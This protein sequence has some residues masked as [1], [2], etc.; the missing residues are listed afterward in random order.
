MP[1]LLAKGPDPACGCFLT[2]YHTRDSP[3]RATSERSAGWPGGPPSVPSS[4][5]RRPPSLKVPRAPRLPP[6]SVPLRAYIEMDAGDTLLTGDKSASPPQAGNTT[7]L[8][9]V[10]DTQRGGGRW[11][12][13]G[14]E[15]CGNTGGM[16]W[17]WGSLCVFISAQ[18]L[19][20]SFI[21]FLSPLPRSRSSA[22]RWQRSLP[23]GCRPLPLGRPLCSP[24][25]RL[26]I[27]E[28]RVPGGPAAPLPRCGLGPPCRPGTPLHRTDDAP[29]DGRRHRASEDGPVSHVPGCF[30]SL[31]TLYRPHHVPPDCRPPPS[32]WR[33][34][35]ARTGLLTA[36][37]SPTRGTRSR[38]G[39]SCLSCR[40]AKPPNPKKTPRLKPPGSAFSPLG[41]ECQFLPPKLLP[42]HLRRGRALPPGLASPKPRL[43]GP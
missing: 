20:L 1:A 39:G 23:G 13:N 30:P 27:R 8:V 29:E 10:G 17:W 16:W 6:Q 34:G 4:K 18:P 38:P 15:N 37:S 14:P 9:G 7:A 42:K 19:T 24:S 35:P 40:L 36:T 33:H 31:V 22:R 32:P 43:D 3:Q 5:N 26:L 12:V 28:R 21:V 11:D 2:S 41:P 25:P